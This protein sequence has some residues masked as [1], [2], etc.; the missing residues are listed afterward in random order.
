MWTLKKGESFLSDISSR[1]LQKLYADEKQAK[2]KLRLLA[3]IRRR[4]GDS[5]DA[6]ANS[7]EKPRRTIHGWL[8]RFEKRGIKAKDA[9]KQP[10]R[11]PALTA[12]QR[13]QLVRELERGPPNNRDGLWSTKEVRELIKRKYGADF[14][15]QH[16]WRILVQ[17]GF[18]LQTPRKRHYLRPSK[19]ELDLF[20]KKQGKKRGVTEKEILL[21]A[22][23]MRQHLA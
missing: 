10:G 1:K 23:R 8:T 15:S 12:K 3:A 7:L 6:I 19:K 14:A 9:I 13:K 18:S 20:K 21:W 16:V 22:H 11:K 17:L 4:K 2:A 5:I